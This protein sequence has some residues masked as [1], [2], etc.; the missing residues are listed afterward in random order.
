EGLANVTVEIKN[1][2]LEGYVDETGKVVIA[3]RFT[4]ARP[5]SGGL[6]A[7]EVGG[8]WEDRGHVTAYHSG[9]WGYIDRTEKRLIGADFDY[10]GSFF[11]GRA[12]VRMG[13]KWGYIDTTGNFGIAARFDEADRFSEGL[14]LVQN[15]GIGERYRYIDSASKP[16]IEINSFFVDVFRGMLSGYIEGVANASFN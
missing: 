14:A 6:A 4:A 1:D 12:A 5:F 10:A 2:S 13:S 9:K 15:Y 16:V 11:E 3:P 8:R 7:V